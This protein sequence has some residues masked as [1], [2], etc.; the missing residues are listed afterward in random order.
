M[1][2]NTNKLIITCKLGKKEIN[3]YTSGLQTSPSPP[4][5]EAFPHMLRH[6]VAYK[7]IRNHVIRHK[8]SLKIPFFFLKKNLGPK[9][10][11]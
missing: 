7:S 10:A 4:E 5:L 2:A 3:F 8:F 6:I 11:I 1:K 9:Y